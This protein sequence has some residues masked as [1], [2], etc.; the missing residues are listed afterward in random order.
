MT[1]QRLDRRQIIKR[2]GALGAVGALAALE[3]PLTAR[4]DEGDRGHRHHEGRH[5][6]GVEGS[7]LATVS[8]T[9]FSPAPAPFP[10]PLTF[11]ALFTYAAGGG[12]VETSQ[13]DQASPTRAS[14][15][16]GAWVRTAEHTFRYTFQ[17]FNFDATG[18]PTGMGTIAE[19]VT[20]NADGNS[21]SGSGTFQDVDLTGKVLDSGT[22]TS[23]ATRIRVEGAEAAD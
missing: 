20:L 18:K 19:T 13:I 3:A 14:P 22:F 11:Q 21:Y 15:G 7:W 17:A 12:L 6:A 9:T 16:H 10:L 2:A 1:D 8:I 5:R 23:A 4:A